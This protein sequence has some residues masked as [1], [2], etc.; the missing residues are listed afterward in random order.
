MG[1]N[2]LPKTVSRQRRDQ[3]ELGSF[4]ALVQHANHLANEPPHIHHIEVKQYIACGLDSAFGLWYLTSSQ[5]WV[6]T[7]VPLSLI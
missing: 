2:S 5:H 7:F 6:H 3:F 1:V 4:F